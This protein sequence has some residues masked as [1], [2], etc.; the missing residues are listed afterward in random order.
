MKTPPESFLIFKEELLKA[1]LEKERLK[2]YYEEKL[3]EVNRELARLKE[4]IS[5]Q[6]EMMRATMEYASNLEDRLEKFKKEVAMTHTQR[7]NT[8]Y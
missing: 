4:Q 5:S 8:V 2:K 6:Q 1:Q 3:S 7:K